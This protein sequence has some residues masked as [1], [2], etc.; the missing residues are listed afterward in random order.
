MDIA[1]RQYNDIKKEKP[2]E[3]TKKQTNN[4]NNNYSNARLKDKTKKIKK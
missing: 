4:N 1:N 3:Q 2:N